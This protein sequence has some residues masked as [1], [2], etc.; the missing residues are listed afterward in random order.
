[1]LHNMPGLKPLV[2]AGC[3]GSFPPC[4]LL[5]PAVPNIRVCSGRRLNSVEIVEEAT[6]SV[7]LRQLPGRSLGR[8]N[9]RHAFADR[10]L[11]WS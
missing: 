5:V 10:L 3:D 9:S 2:Q 8:V 11:R 6:P 1:M 7:K 4:V